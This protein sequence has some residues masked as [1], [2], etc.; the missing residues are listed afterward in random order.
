MNKIIS[1]AIAVLLATPLSALALPSGGALIDNP[2]VEGPVFNYSVPASTLSAS[3]TYGDNFL[4]IDQTQRQTVINGVPNFSIGLSMINPY[5]TTETVDNVTTALVTT[6]TG[7]STYK[8][9]DF[10]YYRVYAF[11][12]AGNGEKFFSAT[13]EHSLLLA[14]IFTDNDKVVRLTIDIP[15]GADGIRV[16]R[17]VDNYGFAEHQDYFASGA[18]YEVYDDNDFGNYGTW[19]YGGVPL[20]ASPYTYTST[21]PRGVLDINQ[22]T[23]ADFYIEDTGDVHSAQS[24]YFTGNLTANTFLGNLSGVSAYLS[25]YLSIGVSTSSAPLYVS[26]TTS[27]NGFANNVAVFNS[28]GGNSSVLL[29]SATSTYASE[30]G[31]GY[32]NARKWHMGRGTN[33]YFNI[34][35]S[36]VAIDM[37]IAS[38]TGYVGLGTD[39]P[40]AKLEVAGGD[41][42]L[43]ASTGAVR[44]IE[45]R[46]VGGGAYPSVGGAAR[47]KGQ[48]GDF[49]WQAAG[50]SAMQLGAYHE[51]ILQ[52]GR[53]TVSDLSFASGSGAAYNTRVINSNAGSIALSVEGAAS[54]SGDYLQLTAN[55]G[56][57]GGILK[58]TS[59][60]NVGIGVT[61]PTNKLEVA[62][63]GY[64]SGNLTGANITA[65]GTLSVTGKTTL[66]N[67]STTNI[68]NS[69]FVNVTGT[70]TTGGLSVASLNGVL[71]GTNGAVS[72]VATSTL[73]L[74]GTGTA[75]ATYVPY[76]GASTGV[77]LGSQ[78]FTTTG[79]STLGLASTSDLTSS[80]T[81]YSSNIKTTSTTAS[82]TIAGALRVG[83]NASP[84]L[85]KIEVSGDGSVPLIY[86]IN[87]DNSGNPLIEARAQ[88]NT[89]GVGINY[90]TVKQLVGNGNLYLSGAGSGSVISQSN[91]SSNGTITGTVGS[92]TS[93][94]GTTTITNALSVG[95]GT[96]DYRLLVRSKDNTATTQ[97]IRAESNNGLQGLGITYTGL[98]GQ[99]G[100]S[101]DLGVGAT[102]T[103]RVWASGGLSFSN[104]AYGTDPG[105]DNIFLGKKVG[106][107]TLTAPATSLDI[108]GAVRPTVTSSTTISCASGIR[109]AIIY[110]TTD[111]HFYGCKVA[112]WAQL[113]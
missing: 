78:T 25:K 49:Y 89:T 105:L 26:T 12:V 47:I 91:F 43:S 39:N 11:T 81:L 19:I 112:G 6:V 109:G 96:G 99:T 53:N 38:G 101:F 82:S 17:N 7:S 3:S 108:G 113:D 42:Y 4:K 86:A 20:P 73:G 18:G 83:A 66:G 95:G 10:I 36:N 90:N 44:T 5:S 56:S 64:F 67:A 23:G 69:G 32:G 102:T 106:I 103:A 72:A 34:V 54:Q 107:N 8:T 70:T 41:M 62:G 58:V 57:A 97:I 33:G 51:I 28:T 65:T 24:G 71:W 92:F 104:Y 74:L 88:N 14:E 50:G 21:A 35:E 45:F 68:T 110:S 111:D 79:K 63:N 48:H 16:Y 40:G 22:N 29:D 59:A 27:S 100:T 55:G 84:T 13:Y 85:G 2:Y 37:T 98:Y 76:T 52:G 46:N 87:T 15:A 30:L 9:G 80:G 93:S 94:T 75:S 61:G 77:N 1:I 31:F 60:G